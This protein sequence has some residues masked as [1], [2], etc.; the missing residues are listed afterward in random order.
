MH[1]PRKSSPR[2]SP[3]DVGRECGCSRHQAALQ[4][5]HGTVVGEE[6]AEWDSSPPV[7][8]YPAIRL[9]S[10]TCLPP[11]CCTPVPEGRPQCTS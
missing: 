4:P 10:G 8:P 9:S 6:A 2:C 1:A 7:A 3:Q 5:R 11:S